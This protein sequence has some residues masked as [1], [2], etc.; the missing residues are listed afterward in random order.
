M[1]LSYNGIALVKREDLKAVQEPGGPIAVD[2]WRGGKVKRVEV[3]R[4]KLGVVALVIFEQ[5]EFSQ[6][7]RQRGLAAKISPRCHTPGARSR[8][9]PNFRSDDPPPHVLLG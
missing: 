3:A 9:S 7:S 4:G 6:G 5:R 2:V 1:L 8:L